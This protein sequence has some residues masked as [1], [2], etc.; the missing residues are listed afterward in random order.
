MRVFGFGI[1]F[2]VFSLGRE[3]LGRVGCMLFVDLIYLI[4][5]IGK[6]IVGFFYCRYKVVG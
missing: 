5:F 2:S 4:D 1:E 6:E 3:V